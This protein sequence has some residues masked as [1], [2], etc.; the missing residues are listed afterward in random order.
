MITFMTIRECY[1]L[2]NTGSQLEVDS[3]EY[4]Q[5]QGWIRTNRKSKNVGFIELNDGT[6]FKNA[7]LVYEKDHD[8][9]E[10]IG[11]FG[12]SHLKSSLEK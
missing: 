3:I 2:V 11:K 9:F 4:V 6:Y 8:Q 7:Q 5:L 12:V 10:E 1:E